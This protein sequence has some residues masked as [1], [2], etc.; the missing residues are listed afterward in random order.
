[1]WFTQQNNSCTR[2]CTNI[3]EK[4]S[5]SRQSAV[6][7]LFNSTNHSFEENKLEI[8]PKETKWFKRGQKEAIFVK[9]QPNNKQK[10]WSQNQA[11]F[12]LQRPLPS[13]V[14]RTLSYVSLSLRHS[15]RQPNRP[16]GIKVKLPKHKI[17][18][19]A[20]EVLWMRRK[21]FNT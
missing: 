11:V 17:I 14:Y 9:K 15:P 20:D 8:L 16:A 5:G 13:N 7:L 21:M 4:S 19:A 12:R 18:C 10:Q 1:M 2:S 3:I 6:H